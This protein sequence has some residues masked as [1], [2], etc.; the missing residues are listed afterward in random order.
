MK[1]SKIL[2]VLEKVPSGTKL[3]STAFGNLELESIV[4]FFGDIGIPFF[5]IGILLETLAIT[6]IIRSIV[7]YT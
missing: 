5:L 1:E 3:Y 6:C 4:E 2:K 7:P